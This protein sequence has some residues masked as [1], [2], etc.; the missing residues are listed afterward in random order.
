MLKYQIHVEC[1]DTTVLRA[2]LRTLFYSLHLPEDVV[3]DNRIVP[4]K[5]VG[6]CLSI[7]QNIG[8]YIKCDNEINQWQSLLVVILCKFFSY[9]QYSVLVACFTVSRTGT[10]YC[11]LNRFYPVLLNTE[12]AIN[13]NER[14]LYTLSNNL[15]AATS[16]SI[17]NVVSFVHEC[18]SSCTFQQCEVQRR[19]EH[20]IVTVNKNND[21]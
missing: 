16:N 2:A 1:S 14:P 9:T 21:I 6:C 4:Y 7:I 3:S 19:C 12:Q 15:V 18:N 11:L 13:D 5:A 20:E 10:N 8:Q 17:D